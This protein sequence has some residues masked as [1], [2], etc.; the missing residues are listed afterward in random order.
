MRT[1]VSGRSRLVPGLKKISKIAALIR[2]VTD[3][4]DAESLIKDEPGVRR[5]GN[6]R[7]F[8]ARRMGMYVFETVP[9][10]GGHLS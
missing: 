3:V 9:S 7:Y 8:K 6:P 4:R 2:D 1:N 5:V 10:G